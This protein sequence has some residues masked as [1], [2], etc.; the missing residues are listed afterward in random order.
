MRFALLFATL[1]V[2]QAMSVAAQ[3][4]ASRDLHAAAT[5]G[6]L[7]ALNA[8]LDAGIG[9]DSADGQRQ[10]ALLLA[11]A[12]DHLQ[13]FNALLAR[14]ASVNAL[15]ANKDTPWLLAGALGR[16]AMLE[17]M[18]ALPPE[19]AP[20]LSLRNR[21]GGSALIPACERGHVET[22]ALLTRRSKIDVNLVNNL[23]WTCL[24]EIV[25]LGNG[26][27]RHVAATKLVLA[28]GANV[29]LADREGVTPLAHARRRGQVEI[30][31]L[32][33]AAKAR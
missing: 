20:D 28:A 2:F 24:L 1:A 7:K 23:G 32:L 19:R 29:N 3:S 17:A 15:A 31:R 8:A 5:Q 10:S 21:F 25:I 30:A 14:G 16:T 33:E 4:L 11:V 22:I 13:V 26:G 6:D 18:L 27:P 12:G 9:V